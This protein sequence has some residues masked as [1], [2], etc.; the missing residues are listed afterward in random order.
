MG[1][2]EVGK[3]N[4]IIAV[5]SEEQLEGVYH[6]Q[7]K[8]NHLQNGEI[9]LPPQIFLYFGSH[10][11]QHVIGVHDDVHEGIQETEESRVTTR[12][13]FNTPPNGDRHNAMMYNM[14]CGYLII[15]FAHH[16]EERIEEFCE[17]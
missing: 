12:C 14:Q 15:S 1:S 10:S 7:N 4:G 11:G 6:H 2:N 17:F 3:S 9:F 8:L 16:K 13:E 5:I